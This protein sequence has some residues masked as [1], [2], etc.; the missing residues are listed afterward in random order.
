MSFLDNAK[1][2]AKGAAARAQQ[3]AGEAVDKSRDFAVEHKDQVSGAID[4]GGDLVNKGTKGKFAK[5][6][7]TVTTKAGD[8]VDKLEKKPEA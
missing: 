8:A 7:D 1:N 5:H 6:V 4:K 2:I 3:V